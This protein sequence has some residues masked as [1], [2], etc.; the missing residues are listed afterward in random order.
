MRFERRTFTIASFTLALAVVTAPAQDAPSELV[1][2]PEESVKGIT[3]HELE[4]HMR[5]LASD[6]LRGRDTA[7][8]EIKIAQEYLAA[9][10]AAAG[11]EPVGDRVGGKAT[12]FAKF[13]LERNSPDPESTK[14]TL[15]YDHEGAL[16]E[17]ALEYGTGFNALPF[18][19]RTTQLEAPA[20]FAGHGVVDESKQFNDYKDLDVK[21]RVV[22]VL[23]GV[24]EGFEGNRGNIFTKMNEAMSRGA[25][26]LV[27]LKQPGVNT[28]T[29]RFRVGRGGVSLP[30][31]ETSVPV[32]TL[33]DNATGILTALSGQ[34]LEALK[35]GPVQ[36]LKLR[37]S[38]QAKKETLEDRNIVA[39]FP[40]SDPEKKKEV[41]VFSAHL[42]HD[43]VNDR[44][45]IMNG[46]DD[47]A[48]GSSAIMEIAEAF[49]TGPKPGRSVAFLWVSGEE[50]GL[51]GSH[52]FSDHVT[53][54][55]EYKI[56]ADINLDMVSRN[57]DREVGITPSPKHPEYNSLVIAGQAACKAEEVEPKF[58]ADEFF[59][60]TD[61]YN[62]ARKGI[63]VIFFFSGLHEDYHRPTD[64]VS[65]A[66]FEKA[67]RI[68]R[69]AFRLGWHVASESD[70]P[71]KV[72]DQTK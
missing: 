3:A 29:P 10:L 47:N 4:A 13:P 49:G 61:S 65:K 30:S 18:F 15:I 26:A 37:I 44:G 8:P 52:W 68:A 66:D 53:L 22:L 23:D 48:S 25:Y 20:V 1:P 19:N 9:Q 2:P 11:A 54:P 36:G 27:V 31:T 38:T 71:K 6:F 62:F 46:S 14:L 34:K 35:Y 12:F 24:P 28:A 5:F 57:A 50:K 32:L 51:L 59:G 42:D 21:N 40:G 55:D 33:E 16:R 70:A 72:S 58:N 43:G 17:E 63:P 69:V 45:E 56:V 67:A 60:R 7:S 39:L 64:D 41:I